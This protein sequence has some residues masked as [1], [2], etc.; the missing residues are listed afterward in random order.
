MGSIIKGA[1]RNQPPTSRIVIVAPFWKSQS[2]YPVLLSLLFD[3]P[4]FI[5]SLTDQ[6]L[7]QQSATSIPASWS[8]AGHIAQLRSFCQAEEFSKQASEF[9]LASCRDKSI[10]VYNS[11]FHKW[12]C[13]GAQR[14]RN[15]SSGPIVDIV[16]FWLSYTSA[17]SSLNSYKST[18]SSVH[19][20]IEGYPV[21]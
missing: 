21:G 1:I 5:T 10:K 9:P 11:L 14:D 20:H 13:W 7:F 8:T 2:W 18:I 4:Q 3:F 19:E 12:D 15:T 6:L 16:N 17:Y